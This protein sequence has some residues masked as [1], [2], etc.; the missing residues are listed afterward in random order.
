[1]SAWVPVRLLPALAALTIAI[2]ALAPHKAAR[3][4]VLGCNDADRRCIDQI[5][6][7][8]CAEV[9]TS[10][11]TCEALAIEAE[12]IWT[13]NGS[14]GAGELLVI[15]YYRL[16]SM[17]DDASVGHS[18]LQRSRALALDVVAADPE[19][20]GAMQMLA[21]L[22][23]ENREQRIAWLRRVVEIDPDWIRVLT[24]ALLTQGTREDFLEVLEI[25]EDQF[26]V[27]PPGIDR[28]QGAQAIHSHLNRS[29]R[30]GIT[31]DP[32]TMA[33]LQELVRQESDWDRVLATLSSPSGHAEDVSFALE[34]ACTLLG[35]FG[36]DPC[37]DGIER[38]V[39]AARAPNE[40]NAQIL[41]DAAAR[42]ITL[43]PR[44][45]IAIDEALQARR[46]QF[47]QWLDEFAGYGLD[48]VTV[49]ESIGS[50]AES[51]GRWIEVRREIVSRE[52]DDGEARFQLGKVYYDRR[53]WAESIREF[54][55]A[56]ELLPEE[57]SYRID[58]YL[59]QARAQV[60]APP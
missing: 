30:F 2:A 45:G 15:V 40:P 38:T 35:F 22:E 4:D 5:Y 53:H 18:Y 7:S 25:L 57:E 33:E 51:S 32:A 17:S 50:I 56:R 55:R 8:R 42:G 3:A 48:S 31:T 54:E 20:V 28:W 47:A 41:A 6:S 13:T 36:S 21:V 11:A 1:M 23:G 37:L 26:R 24:R 49:L 27:A 9:G 19:A 44:G 16:A 39:L 52:P 34:T 29:S 46:R 12:A 43:A 58:G 59:R 60:Q 10:R 14:T